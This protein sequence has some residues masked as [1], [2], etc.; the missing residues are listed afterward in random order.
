MK[1]QGTGAVDVPV[2]GKSNGKSWH[3]KAPRQE[4]GNSIR[5]EARARAQVLDQREQATS[6]E[7]VCGGTEGELHLTH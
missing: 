6:N 3:C 5:V 1:R 2:A 7:A 4:I